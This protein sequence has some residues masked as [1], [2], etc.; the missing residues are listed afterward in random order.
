MI[1]WLPTLFLLCFLG[2][3]V[4]ADDVVLF[5]DF[6]GGTGLWQ[7]NFWG[8]SQTYNVSP[9]HSFTDSPLGNYPGNS[10]LLASTIVGA[11][12]TGYM[13][14]R[15][16]FWAYYQIEYAFDVCYVEATRDGQFWVPLGSL[17]GLYPFWQ[18]MTY[19]LGAFAGYPGVKVRFRFVTDPQTSYDG[20]YI[21]DFKVI[22][23]PED[24][25]GP[26]I[27]HQGPFA[28]QGTPGSKS[29]YADVWDA[30]G[31]WEEHC[32]FRTDGT[33][34]IEA[35]LDSV[36]GE[37]YYHTIP[38]QEAGTLV[39][40]YFEATDASPQ[41]YTSISDTFAYLA[42]Q[43]LIL[44]DGL[45]ETILE[46]LP[47]NRAAVRFQAHNAGYV[48]SALIR[49]YTDSFHPLDSIGVYIW[50]DSLG[51]PGPILAGPFIVY[52]ASTPEVPEAWT[53]VDLRPALVV[54]PDTFHVGL[55]FATTGSVPVMALSYDTPP[56]Y[57]RSSMDVGSGFQVVD[58]GDFHIRTVVGDLT[59]DDLLAP[60]ELNG[61]GEGDLLHLSW[62]APAPLDNLLRYE[63]ERQ[64]E[65]IGQTQ[66]LETIYTDTLTDLPS[67]IY[68]Y[69]VRARYSTG[70]SPFSDPWD[71]DW[72]GTGVINN[73][74]VIKPTEMSFTAF[75][76]PTNGMITI[77]PSAAGNAAHQSF[78]LFDIQ[79]REVM[80]VAGNL[81]VGA[82]SISLRLPEG[83][84]AGVYILEGRARA[85][86]SERVKI[87]Y[88][89]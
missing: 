58:F 83:L 3:P 65:I 56:V 41:F 66:Y 50:A 26:L 55:E 49:I 87:V 64:G 17:T 11:N 78:V 24:V 37:R 23:T 70:Y 86:R 79:G 75:P 85:K 30:S 52:P 45:S 60:G 12:L 61:V 71:Y 63:I 81:A 18:L 74:P 68:S 35:P 34:F 9:T 27:I 8:L 44:D 32:F 59:P 14:G 47:G 76:N 51:L 54:A 5:D 88:L 31:I 48:A 10:V 7:T 38:R 57:F 13:G 89:P 22:G 40:Y 33:P 28:Y 46:A 36:V 42:G 53:P 72:A 2:H 16:E 69:R 67:G 77:K 19:D 80:R 15:L 6:E 84:S 62:S 21:D 20:I 29:L 1:R 4:L 39:E 43:M 82:N 73:N 25:S